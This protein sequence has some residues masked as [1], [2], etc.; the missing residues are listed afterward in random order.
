VRHDTISPSHAQ[1]P[2]APPVATRP[3]R[4]ERDV[5]VVGGG[6][7]G[8]AAAAVLAKA[9]RSV[10]L[11]EA[12]DRLGGACLGIAPDGHRYDVGV[13]VLTGVGAGGSVATLC[14]RLGIALPTIACDPAIQVAL[15]GHRVDF[16]R[17]VDGWWPEIQREFS[18]EEAGWHALV[19]D[20]AALAADR[21]RLAAAL[22][23]LP[24]ETLR[25]RLRCWRT[26]AA[27]RWRGET[28]RAT[29]ELRRAAGTSFRET[30]EEHGLGTA[31]RQTLE[32][33][34][35]YLALRDTGEC[36]TLEA[37]VA[38]QRLHGGV[39]VVSRGPAVLADLLADG[40]G[41]HGGEIRTR[42]TVARCVAARGRIVGVTT[43]AGETIRARWVVAAVPPGT[44]VDRLLPQSRRRLRRPR[45]PEGPWEPSHVAQALGVTIPETFLPSALGWLCLIVR[46]SA[47]PARDENLVF[48]RRVCDGRSAGAAD[49]L[50]RLCVGR[51]VPP[52]AAAT[53]EAIEEALLGALDRLIPGVGSI[54]RHGW[55]G[56]AP[57]LG[58]VWGRPMG[59]VRYAATAPEWLGRRGSSH[60]VG[61][62]GLLAVGEWT[63]PGRLVSDVVEGAM[64]AAD[65]IAAAG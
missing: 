1:L 26:L 42:T 28:R 65:A 31:S 6:I 44:L 38:L 9:G 25:D 53:E 11:L 21:D 4:A 54:A 24:A 32:A 2:L 46:D 5:V 10:L 60:R 36:S 50:V 7:G 57:V 51:F 61:W 59:A 33:C 62:P 17:S 13:G 23:P 39:A 49:G 63:Y 52:T 29:Q 40:I 3:E 16:A 45:L 48:V 34:L 41:K 18:E 12:S 58:E 8:L 22:P 15:P 35:W 20:L 19:S 64:Q 43:E 47:R 27:R 55:I 30:L 56:T 14:E 37:A